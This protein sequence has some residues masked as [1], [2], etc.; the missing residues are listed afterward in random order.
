MLE[1]INEHKRTYKQDLATSVSKIPGI[2][3]YTNSVSLAVSVQ[4]GGK[5]FK[6]MEEA[7]AVSK[8]IP[9]TH[10]IIVFAKKSFDETVEATKH[11][12]ACPVVIMPYD[13]AVDYMTLLLTLKS[14]YKEIKRTAIDHNVS[15]NDIPDNIVG[16]DTLMEGLYIDD[17]TRRWL[18]T[19]IILDDIGNSKLF[20]NP[21][22]YFNNCLKLCRDQQIMWYLATH[23]MAQL[24]PSIRQNATIIYIGR[25]LSNERLDIIHRQTNNGIDINEFREAYQRVADSGKRFLVCDN[26][27]Q[28]I[29]IQ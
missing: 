27:S 3:S 11:L 29:S 26:V 10:L 13:Q 20:A 8:A 22:S 7:I 18:N 5:T 6:F 24:S 23:G 9:E 12:A 19:I 25:G 28:S 4:G 17:F 15:D 16:C 21:D 14:K 1:S 2:N